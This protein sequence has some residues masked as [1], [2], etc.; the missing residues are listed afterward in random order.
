MGG[1]EKCLRYVPGTNSKSKE[2]KAEMLLSET[3]THSWKK[4]NQY[5]FLSRLLNSIFILFF[6]FDA[7]VSLVAGRLS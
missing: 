4:K 3:I 1:F 7:S 6:F 5:A 2:V